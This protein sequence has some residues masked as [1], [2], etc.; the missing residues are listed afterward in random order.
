[1]PSLKSLLLASIATT[2]TF[3]LPLSLFGGSGD[4]TGDTQNGLAPG[5]PCKPL[6]IIFAR[7][8]GETGNVGTATGPPFFQAV[9]QKVGADNMTVQGVKYAAG[10]LSVLSGGDAAGSANM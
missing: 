1:M 6:T 9:A 5:Q 10:F 8:S 2:S 7:G 4:F 3:A